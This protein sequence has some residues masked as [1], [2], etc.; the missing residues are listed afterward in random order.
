MSPGRHLS[1]SLRHQI[2]V[3]T[4]SRLLTHFVYAFIKIAI[5]FMRRRLC[6]ESGV[7][8]SHRKDRSGIVECIPHH[9]VVGVTADRLS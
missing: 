9:G 8:S 5:E 7:N 1:Q 6:I 4:L 3:K 2:T